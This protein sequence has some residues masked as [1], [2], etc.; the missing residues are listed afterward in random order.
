VERLLGLKC[1][2]LFSSL[3]MEVLSDIAHRVTERF[4]EPGE[5]L[6]TQGE[7]GASMFVVVKGQLRVHRGEDTLAV[8]EESAVVGELSAILPGPRTASLTAARFTHV[9]VLDRSLLHEI[10][11]S[12]PE[13]L[14]LLLQ[15]V[16]RRIEASAAPRAQAA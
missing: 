3:G 7:H 12:H 6:I 9:L 5:P 11:Q 1:S 10:A 14:R 8:L 2:R 13:V 4:L 16:V 15:V